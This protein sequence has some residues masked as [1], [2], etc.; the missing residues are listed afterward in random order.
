MTTRIQRQRRSSLVEAAYATVLEH[1][2][3]GMTMARVSRRA[4]LSPGIVN[5]HFR[6]KD[7]L[8]IWVVRH[9]LRLILEDAVRRL[10]AAAGPRG[11]ISAVI[12]A[13]FSDRAFDR[14]TAA[15][16]VSFYAAVASNPEVARLQELV[17]RRQRSNLVP[18]LCALTT[19]ARAATIAHGISVMIDGLWMQRAMS[20]QEITRDQAIAL[21]EDHVAGALAVVPQ[22]G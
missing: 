8:V 15:A 2:I 14:P 12:A 16:W 5:Y 10:K 11:R 22:D 3:D 9:A 21:I 4:G 1:G 13:N 18:A 17:Y 20:S 6:D 7:T 19:R